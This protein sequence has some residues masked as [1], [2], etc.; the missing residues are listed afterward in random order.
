MA[1]ETG[2]KGKRDGRHGEIIR[3][4]GGRGTAGCWSWEMIIHH[5]NTERDEENVN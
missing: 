3:S 5:L 2:V 1:R 4:G